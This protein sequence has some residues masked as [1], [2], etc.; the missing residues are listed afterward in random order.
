MELQGDRLWREIVA[1]SFN[2]PSDVEQTQP[3]L[4]RSDT[5]G[6]WLFSLTATAV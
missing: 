3:E 4:S 6:V 1:N 2:L 5:P